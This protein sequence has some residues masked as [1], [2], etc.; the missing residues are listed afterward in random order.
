MGRMKVLLEYKEESDA[1]RRAI[2]DIISC[3]GHPDA[4]E[5]LV[6]VIA[7]AKEALGGEHEKERAP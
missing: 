7:V 4:Q 6:N 2:Y 3:C 1:L 5:A